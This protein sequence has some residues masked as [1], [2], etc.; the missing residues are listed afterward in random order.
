MSSVLQ[1]FSAGLLLAATPAFA[2]TFSEWRA[3]N[4][5]HAEL[6]DPTISGPGADPDSDSHVNLAE[7]AHGL[8]P[9]VRE[10]V[11]ITFTPGPPGLTLVFPQRIGTTDLLYRFE[12]STD[13]EPNDPDGSQRLLTCSNNP[14]AHETRQSRPKL[15]TVLAPPTGIVLDSSRP[16][17][18]NC[19][20]QSGL[21]PKGT[22]EKILSPIGSGPAARSGSVQQECICHAG[23]ITP[24]SKIAP[25]PRRHSRYTP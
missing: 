19:G 2:L 21:R 1:I 5:P 14:R 3:A 16:L 6:S 22:E 11:A 8:N 15:A 23:G 10:T 17:L 12:E 9:R 25:N 4:F 24:H 18:P 7:H 13:P 20:M